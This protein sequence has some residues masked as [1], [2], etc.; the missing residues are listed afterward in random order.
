MKYFEISESHLTLS[1]VSMR[2]QGERR[3]QAKKESRRPLAEDCLDEARVYDCI[4]FRNCTLFLCF[5]TREKE[6]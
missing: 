6:W 3:L 4:I 5:S 2:E 1:D